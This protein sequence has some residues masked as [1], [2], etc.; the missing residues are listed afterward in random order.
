MSILK[1]PTLFLRLALISW[2]ALLFSL[3][4]SSTKKTVVSTG[5]KSE[6]P[7]KG[8][9]SDEQL[10]ALKYMFFN[11]NKERQLGNNDK[12][13]ELYAQC[14]RLD[15]KHHASMYEIAKIYQEQNKLND[16]LFFAAGASQLEPTNEW[17]RHLTATLYMDVRL[18]ADGEKEFAKLYRDFPG[19]MDYAFEYAAALITNGKLTEAIKVYDDIEK[20][21]GI[22]PELIMEKERLW[23]QMG[24]LDKAVAEVERL[25]AS[26]PG[27][28]RHYTMLVELYQANSMPEKVLQTTER[29]REVDADSPYLYLAL[30]GYY[31]STNQFKKSFENLKLAF[32]SNELEHDLKMQILTSYMPLLQ[33]NPEMLQ[34]G[35][36]LAEI[37][38]TTH[39][40]DAISLSIYG[41]FLAMDQK[42]DEAIIQYRKSLNLDANNPDVWQQLLICY[43]E[44]NNIDGMLQASDSALSYFPEHSVFYLFRGTALTVKKDHKEAVKSLLTGSKLV[45][46]N[47]F[48]KLQ[49][50]T[51]LADNYHTL[52]E[53]EKSD[54]YY[55]KALEIDPNDPL[56]LNNYSYYLSVRKE[57]LEKAEE[58]SRKSNELRPGEPSY[59]DTYGWILYVMGRYAE[60]K[61]WLQK[62][63]DH[64]GS[65]NGTILEHMGDT[66]FKLGDKTGAAEYWKK[67]KDS[68]E[69]SD[70][71]DKKIK[72]NQLYE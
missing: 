62:A 23:L 72:D 68:G 46:D 32:A 69:H 67:A 4:C 57:K 21:I 27:N 28:I 10:I 7:S 60:A 19:N 33:G 22:S 48:Q 3:G 56:V 24:K 5:S 44:K 43:S 70:L 58:M 15:G 64:G 66:L 59:E 14:V 13:L 29:M 36:E 34:Q 31:R 2:V 42:F 63:L 25:I 47:D 61:E 45:V 8:Q 65:S 41:D 17:Y 54:T 38:A 6:A 26:D 53:H 18:F 12:A 37:L 20:K 35:L 50:Y 40:D 51:R 39:S 55:E 30:A 52:K 11:A 9:L 71:L 1:T 16:A 49:F